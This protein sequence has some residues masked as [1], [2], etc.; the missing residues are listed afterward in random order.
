MPPAMRVLPLPS[1]MNRK[2]FQRPFAVR[3]SGERLIDGLS[4]IMKFSDPAAMPFIAPASV[5]SQFRIALLP[6]AIWVPHCRVPLATNSDAIFLNSPGQLGKGAV[7]VLDLAQRFDSVDRLG[8][9]VQFPPRR[10]TGL[11]RQP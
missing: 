8:Q 10:H 6:V 1:P 9:G 11:R 4:M 7:H 2:P 5:V 3:P